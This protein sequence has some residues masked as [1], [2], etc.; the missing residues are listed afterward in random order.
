MSSE[1][2]WIVVPAN[3]GKC[4]EIHSVDFVSVN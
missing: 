1:P 4:Y 2:T 3:G